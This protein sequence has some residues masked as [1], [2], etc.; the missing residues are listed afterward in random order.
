MH[1][2]TINTFQ[3]RFYTGKYGDQHLRKMERINNVFR[4]IEVKNNDRQMHRHRKTKTISHYYYVVLRRID[5]FGHLAR[6]KYKN[7]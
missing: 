3:M 4:D 5:S 1:L 2:N 7:M 6:K